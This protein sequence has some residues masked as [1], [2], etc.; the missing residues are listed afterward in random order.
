MNSAEG[1]SIQ[2]NGV[3]NPFDGNKN[4]R[5]VE[6]WLGEIEKMMK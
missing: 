4:V 2:F 5:G 6:D 1:E 3:I